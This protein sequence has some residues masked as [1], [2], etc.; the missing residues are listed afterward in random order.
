[1]KTGT[2]CLLM[3][4]LLV[5]F[6]VMSCA[7]GSRCGAHG[8]P[9]CGW[10]ANLCDTEGLL[11]QGSTCRTCGT[12]GGP[13]CS[14]NTCGSEL[15][16]NS[17]PGGPAFVCER[18]GHVGQP[19]CVN[20]TCVTGVFSGGR[21]V[22]PGSTEAMCNGSMPF[23]IG[24]RDRRTRC[25]L[26]EFSVRANSRDDARACAVRA[27]RTAGY[28]EPEATDSATWTY[29]PFLATSSLT[30]C[31]VVRMPAYSVEDGEFCARFMYSDRTITRGDACL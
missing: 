16:C 22:A 9:C 10:P 19:A 17:P 31:D 27:A 5:A 8:Q 13:C 4:L 14:F 1:M 12:E 23:I 21:C 20:N 28:L 18:C 24:V 11:C 7:D 3:S 6:A 15:F 2:K 29:H 25:R 26:D 30:G